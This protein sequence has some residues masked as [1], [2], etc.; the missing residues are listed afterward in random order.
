[1]RIDT[2]ASYCSG[3]ATSLA[4]VLFGSSLGRCIDNATT[5]LRALLTTIAVNRAVIVSACV[6][7]F[8]IVEESGVGDNDK[9]KEPSSTGLPQLRLGERFGMESILQG[10]L[11]GVAFTGALILGVIETLSRRLNVISISRDW[12]PVL[13]PPDAEKPVQSKYPLVKVDSTMAGINMVCE[14]LAPFIISGF[15]TLVG[16]MRVAVAT[17]ALINSLS[18]WLEFATAKSIAK[19]FEELRNPKMHRVT[20]NTEDEAEE[21]EVVE[22]RCLAWITRLIRPI[23]GW[24]QGQADSL[25][26]YFSNDIWMASFAFAV[27]HT[28]LLSIS[29]T[30]VVFLLNSGYSLRLITIA[31]AVSASFEFTSTIVTPFAVS[32]LNKSAAEEWEPIPSED[33]SAIEEGEAEEIHKPVYRSTSAIARVGLCGISWQFLSLVSITKFPCRLKCRI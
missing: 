17:V 13:A 7:W 3:I 4:I 29:S 20:D 30:T 26:L 19:E 33:S 12:V 32:R 25:R 16:S 24:L 10:H 28:S 31:E 18:I 11:K 14:L 21:S 23:V 27:L 1:M 9:V 6:L 5:R 15:L 8:L 2:D 22:G